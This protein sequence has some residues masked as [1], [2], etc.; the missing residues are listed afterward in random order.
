M[1][2]N[3]RHE[4][5]Y[6]IYCCHKT[7]SLVCL[8]CLESLVDVLVNSLLMYYSL[9]QHTTETHMGNNFTHFVN[10]KADAQESC[11]FFQKLCQ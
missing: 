9:F 1:H 10:I 5:I 3:K 6:L 4:I 11:V 7:K 2:D 8:T